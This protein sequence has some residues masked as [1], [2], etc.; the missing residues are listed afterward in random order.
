[1]SDPLF[2][3]DSSKNGTDLLVGGWGRVVCCAVGLGDGGEPPTE[4]RDL[5]A[6]FGKVSEV[7][8]NGGRLGRKGSEIALVAPGGEVPPVAFVGATGVI[9]DASLGEVMSFFGE[10]RKI[11]RGRGE[12]GRR[13]G[14]RRRG[15]WWGI[16]VWSLS[17][18]FGRGVI[19]G[20]G[21]EKAP[22]KRV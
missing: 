11:E 13:D 3:A 17:G 9:G 6:L 7:E 21:H 15:S 10:R 19:F 14:E 22:R 4:G 18:V 20:C 1:L 5:F 8:N 2:A 12:R 16:L